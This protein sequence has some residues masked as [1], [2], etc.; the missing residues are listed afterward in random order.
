MHLVQEL[1]VGT[2]TFPLT[3]PKLK[4]VTCV[5]MRI[6]VMAVGLS[7]ERSEKGFREVGA[8]SGISLDLR[9]AGWE[10]GPLQSAIA[11]LLGDGST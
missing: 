9:E 11:S 1:N 5:F 10:S 6:Q 2:V 7:K 8:A 4:Y 3:H